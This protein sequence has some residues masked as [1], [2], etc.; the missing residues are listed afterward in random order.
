MQQLARSFFSW[1]PLQIGLTQRRFYGKVFLGKM[2]GLS[3]T[4]KQSLKCFLKWE[5]EWFLT[6]NSPSPWIP[7]VPFSKVAVPSLGLLGLSGNFRKLGKEQN[8][9]EGNSCAKLLRCIFGPLGAI[10]KKEAENIRMV[11]SV[12][13]SW[14]FLFFWS[15]RSPRLKK[16]LSKEGLFSF[17]GLD[18]EKE[19]GNSALL[20]SLFILLRRRYVVTWGV[21]R[22][23]ILVIISKASSGKMTNFAIVSGSS[24]T[25]C[26]SRVY[27]LIS[28]SIFHPRCLV[29]SSVRKSLA[30]AR[31]SSTVI[32]RTIVFVGSSLHALQRD[33]TNLSVGRP[34][35]IRA[36]ANL[37][38]KT[39]VLGWNHSVLLCGSS[40]L[41]SRSSRLV[42]IQAIIL[43][44]FLSAF[45]I[46]SFFRHT[47]CE[48]LPSFLLPPPIP[49]TRTGIIKRMVRITQGRLAGAWAIIA[50]RCNFSPSFQ[51]RFIC[52]RFYW[53]LILSQ[54]L[55]SSKLL[56]LPKT[57]FRCRFSLTKKQP[58]P[59]WLIIVKVAW[60]V[61]L[62]DFWLLTFRRRRIWWRWG[63]LNSRPEEQTKNFYKLNLFKDFELKA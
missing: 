39:T 11:F 49:S 13:F 44:K 48:M 19:P 37:G 30:I 3:S 51:E 22:L 33:L 36:A 45:V 41:N 47:S 16:P 58:K 55:V 4:R 26:C 8:F 10:F 29:L 57:A 42:I 27:A 53:E 40:F 20:L 60:S 6:T 5:K 34:L 14:N 2:E 56:E 50:L 23:P 46:S 9:R 63:E 21:P 38:M 12:C 54:K 52:F 25:G 1:R 7:K 35:A 24:K 59:F 31:A 32:S 61:L 15:Q 43:E 17:R 28:Q 18:V 62:F